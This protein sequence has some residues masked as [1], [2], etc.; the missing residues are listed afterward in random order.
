M[1][2]TTTNPTSDAAVTSAAES[3]AKH[4]ESAVR[5]NDDG[6]FTQS[7]NEVNQFR[8]DHPVD[9]AAFAKAVTNKLKIDQLLP[10]VSLFEA[11]HDFDKIDFTKQNQLTRP[12]VD[13][14]GQHADVN[15]VQRA[16]LANISDGTNPLMNKGAVDSGLTKDQI[17]D[18]LTTRSQHREEIQHLFEKGPDGKSLYDKIVNM[19]GDIPSGKFNQLTG[20]SNADRRALQYLKESRTDTQYWK[21]FFRIKGRDL[22]HGEIKTM[23]EQNNFDYENLKAHGY[24]T[25]AAPAGKQPADPKAAEKAAADKV[26]EKAAA[27]KVAEKA[28]ADKVAEKAAADKVAEKAAAD[29]AA[30]KAAAD[31]VAEKDAADKA[32]EKAAADKALLDQKI[33]DARTVQPGHSYAQTAEALLALAGVND[34]SKQQLHRLAHQLWVADGYRPANTLP[35]HWVLNLSKDIRK[36]K[37][38]AKLLQGLPD[39]YEPPKKNEGDC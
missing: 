22:G 2:S 1:A 17:H 10:Q 25:D 32:A 37:D 23:L 26:A 15:D 16:L 31:K 28:A 14:F 36:N 9:A 35:K 11:Q 39:K 8:H 27:D 5:H 19:N 24:K 21:D 18:G 20:L 33:L 6:M 4:L 30:E 38:V 13:Q 3:T 7:M 29:K 12:F 34:P